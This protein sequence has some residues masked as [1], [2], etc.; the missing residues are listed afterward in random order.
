MGVVGT[1][2]AIAI[3]AV[4]GAA[5]AAVGA[6]AAADGAAAVAVSPAVAEH[7]V[8]GNEIKSFL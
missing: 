7:P 6:A 3:M 1:A 5:V 4:A 8:V 2:E